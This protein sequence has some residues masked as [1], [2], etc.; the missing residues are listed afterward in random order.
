MRIVVTGKT[1]QVTSALQALRI[2]DIEVIAL[3]R[4]EMDL[5]SPSTVVKSLSQARPD[6]IIS[7]AAYTA[8]DKAEAEP[9]LAFA[10]NAEGA[11]IVSTAAFQLSVPIIH[12]STDYVFNGRNSAS[13]IE[14]HPTD[15]VSV[16]GQSKLDGERRVAA[17]NPNH[18]I[19]RT[20]WVYSTFGRNFL[21][22]MLR[23]SEKQDE[24]RVVG[25]QHGC[26]TSATD[27]ADAVVEIARHLVANPETDLRGIFHIVGTGATNWADFAKFIFSVLEEKTG[28][29]ISVKEIATV[30]YP[31]AA[32]RPAN[33]VLNC[34]KLESVYGIRLPR[35]QATTRTTV[36]QILEAAKTA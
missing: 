14:T 20:A 33:S 19:L 17:A 11:E 23:L 6:V 3:G 25:D 5:S 24:V 35:W 10:I 22:T 1:G 8:V 13:Y 16:Y 12:L 4:P 18:V 29:H 15:P 26:P 21:R 9:D 32:A 34:D 36:E 7:S 28:R 31:T 30:D 27:I 2:P